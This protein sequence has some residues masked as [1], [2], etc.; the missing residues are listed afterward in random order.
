MDAIK[1]EL[2]GATRSRSTSLETRWTEERL[3]IRT[4]SRYNICP[5]G[6][7]CKDSLEMAANVRPLVTDACTDGQECAHHTHAV[8]SAS[9]RTR[10][11]IAPVRPILHKTKSDSYLVLWE[12]TTNLAESIN[13]SIKGIYQCKQQLLWHWDKKTHRQVFN[14]SLTKR[15][16]N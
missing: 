12:K 11:D 1:E 4:A 2:F 8:C 5:R 14:L 16:P 6:C 13:G 10:K 7:R 15:A 3:R 9:T